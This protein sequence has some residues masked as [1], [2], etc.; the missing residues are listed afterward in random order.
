[1]LG[2][3]IDV[4]RQVQGLDVIALGTTTREVDEPLVTFAASEGIACIRGDTNDVAGRFLSAMAAL[5]VDAG[6][7]LNGDSPLNRPA[8]LAEAIRV[9]RTGAWDMVSNV[10][11]RTFPYGVS[12]EVIGLPAM[13][14][15]YEVMSDGGHR[16][17]VTQYFYERSDTLRLYCMTSGN[18]AYRGLQLAVDT[19]RDLDRFAWIQAQ[20]G[21]RL[22]SASL[23]EVCALGRAF[24]GTASDLAKH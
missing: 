8:L 19:E 3:A 1:L 6:L 9:F 10:P 22:S 20:L 24:D 17:H 7:R 2:Y 23:D 12:V 18:D 14:Q 16:E 15:A 4:C 11:G 21:A 5:G 13:K